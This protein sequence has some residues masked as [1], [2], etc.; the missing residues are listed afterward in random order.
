MFL[1]T[2]ERV[3]GGW[4]RV[5]VSEGGGGGFEF[6]STCMLGSNKNLEQE[7]FFAL[8]DFSRSLSPTQKSSILVIP[9]PSS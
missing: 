6:E 3:V 9:L 2:A 8:A 4:T 1:V 5:G 7:I